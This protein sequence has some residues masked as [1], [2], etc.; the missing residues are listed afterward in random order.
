MKDKD[1][2]PII[3]VPLSFVPLIA[4]SFRDW[5]LSL[6]LFYLL[7]PGIVFKILKIPLKDLGFKMPKSFRSTLVLLLFSII[8]SFIGTLFPEMKNYYPRFTYST[9]LDFL[10]YELLFGLIMFAHEAFFRGFLLFPLARKNK[11]LGIILQD[12][13]YTIIHVGK[14]T[15]EIPYAFV[16]GVIFAMID[17][18]EESIGPSFIVHW[19]GSAFFDVLCAIT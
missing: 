19:L 6:L 8:L 13:P 15:M 17:L 9:P 3:L 16:A 12:I 2:V 10:F 11:I 7:I 14:P 1:I 5:I 18:K 4:M